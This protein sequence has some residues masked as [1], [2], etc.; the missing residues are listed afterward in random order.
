MGRIKF[1][2][3]VPITGPVSS[4]EH[5]LRATLE[6]EQLGFD[7]AVIGDH[8][9]PGGREAFARHRV[10]PPGGGSWR[11]PDATA[12]PNQFEMIASLSW[13]AG[14]TSR[15][16]LGSGVTPLPLR[17]P[18]VLAKQVA[19]LDHLS[20]GRFIFGVGIANKTDKE[21]FQSLGIP[22]DSYAGRYE[23]AGEFIA[24]MRAIWEQ[25]VATFQGRHL[26][27]EDVT[28]Y[29]QPARRVPVWL[30]AGTLAGG[31]D[32]PPVKFAL[33]HADGLMFPYLITPEETGVMI[34]EFA[35]TAGAAGRDVSDFAWCCQRKLAVGRTAADAREAVDWLARDQADMWKFVGFMQG[36]GETGA[37]HHN[38]TVPAGTPDDICRLLQSY[39]DAG[40]TWFDIFFIHPD[41]DSLLDQM[42]LFAHE[43]M[44]AF[45]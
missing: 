18:V 37:K 40:S 9:A 29:P 30:G 24:A 42:R 8:I 14:Q 17:D 10:T 28:I 43:V 36:L 12:D 31:L 7:A 34:R 44:P 15:I 41:F 11:H 22:F 19:T 16:E 1:G 35:T 45:A 3:R 38:A 33:D 2:V 6:A 4:R 23:Q 26:V 27:F 25:P 13:L 39:V 21:E 20:G 32:Y 5:L